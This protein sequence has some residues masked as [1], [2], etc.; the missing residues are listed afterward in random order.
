VKC[1]Q[2]VIPVNADPRARDTG[3]DSGPSEVLHSH[4]KRLRTVP[5]LSII[6]EAVSFQ[7]SAF[8]DQPE[9]F[10]SASV[11]NLC[12]KS[13]NQVLTADR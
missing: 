5:N 10:Q 2:I 7:Q 11:L 13:E 9:G 3:Q 8:S 4:Q 12:L 6:K 1:R